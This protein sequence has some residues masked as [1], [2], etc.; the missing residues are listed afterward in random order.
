MRWPSWSKEVLCRSQIGLPLGAD[1]PILVGECACRPDRV[2][3]MQRVV[4]QRIVHP[5]AIKSTTAVLN[6]YYIPMGGEKLIIT[7]VAG[8]MLAI[9]QTQQND[10]EPALS[11]RT[12][13]VSIQCYPVA[14]FCRN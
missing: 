8:H 4:K 13:Y 10:W 6:D 1:H 12:I 7:K 5:F 2:V 9:G 11:I 14:H 3:S